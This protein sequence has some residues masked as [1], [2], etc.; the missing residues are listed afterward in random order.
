M[1]R[2]LAIAF[3]VLLVCAAVL[4]ALGRGWL[5]RHEGPG[6]AERP[7][8]S[9][10][11][12]GAAPHFRVRAA[13][14]F[15]Q[16]PG[17]PDYATAALSPERLH[18]LCRDECYHPS[19]QRKRVTRIEVVRMRPQLREDEPIDSLVEDPWRVIPWPPDP[20]GCSV[21][22]EDPEFPESGRDAVYYVR[23]VEEP[24]PAV[25]GANLRCRWD[26]EGNC[27][28]TDPCYGDEEMT[29]YQ[30]DCLSTVEERAW[31]SPIFVDQAG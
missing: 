1:R 20:A 6:G 31:S 19:D 27:V 30:E 28:A 8:G 4:V 3:A 2:V 25:N 14:A 23:A 24:S 11:A 13:G 16:K 29:P 15:H 7:M 17:C 18:H 9:E 12:M 5:G 26:A 21:E 10:V 22:F